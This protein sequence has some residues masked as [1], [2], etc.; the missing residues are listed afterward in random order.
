MYD[1]VRNNTYYINAKQLSPDIAFYKT[2]KDAV[3]GNEF[4]NA[5]VE[6][7]RTIP[8][9]NNNQYTLQI[10]LPTETTSIV[11]NTVD[12]HTMDFVFR[13][14]NDINTTASINP[15]D[16]TVTWEKDQDFCSTSLPVT[17]NPVTKQFTIT[18]TVSEGK[19]TNQLQHEWIKVTH[20]A[21]G[22][23]RYIHVYVIDQFKFEE[24]PKLTKVDN[25]YKLSFKI[26]KPEYDDPDNPGTSEKVYPTT[27]YPIDVKF[28]TNTLNA[29][30]IENG[31]TNYGL[32]GVS[33]EGTSQLCTQSNFE[34]DYNNPYSSTSTSDMTHWYFQQEDNYWDFWYTYSI[35]NYEQTNDGVV[36]IYFKDVTDHISY[37]DVNEVGLFMYINY[38]GKYYSVPVT[39]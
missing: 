34:T 32:F 19:V 37:A 31:V 26:P 25:G 30:G 10:K 38:F 1:I 22:L 12:E 29:Y 9:I 5:D 13:Y 8:D 16:F 14:V 3:D 36:N 33:I 21:S 35:K 18:A 23:T 27:L 7:D 24:Y 20:N 28:T 11:F 6:V 39:Q 4:V 2:L 17:Y 15:E